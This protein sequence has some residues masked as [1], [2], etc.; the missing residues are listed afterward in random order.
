LSEG[1]VTEEAYYRALA[2]HLGCQYY[3]GEPPLAR[4]FDAVKG[5]RCGVAPLEP[6]SAGPRIVVAPRAQFVPQL[7]DATLSGAIRSGSFALTSPQRFAS[8][9]RARHSA[10]LFDVALGRLPSSLTARKGLTVLQV[11]VL[12]AMAIAALALGVTDFDALQAISSGM[13]WL[14]FSAS[15]MLRSMAAVANRA[16]IDTPD[17]TDDELPNYTV[18]L[19]RGGRRRGADQGD[20][21]VRLSQGQA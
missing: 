14:I 18:A 2:S 10:E 21:R 4:A 19:S 7:I 12:G 20:R 6:S 15:V 8:L 9:V 13:L 16:E 5:L 11:A 17:L 3:C 1:K